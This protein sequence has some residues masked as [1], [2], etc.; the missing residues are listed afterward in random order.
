MYYLHIF[1]QLFLRDSSKPNAT[2]HDITPEVW[3]DDLL[4]IKEPYN[5]TVGFDVNE[6][7]YL[8]V[9]GTIDI[10]HACR[11]LVDPIV[12][13]SQTLVI[14]VQKGF[15]QQLKDRPECVYNN[16]IYE[17]TVEIDCSDGKIVG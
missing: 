8:N 9:K 11:A 17:T 2:E 15:T 13:G 6:K 3:M 1:F 16:N 10:S 12:K 14:A 5:F 7:K 4:L